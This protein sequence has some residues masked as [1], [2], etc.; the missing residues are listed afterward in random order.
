MDYYWLECEICNLQ[1]EKERGRKRGR[2]RERVGKRVGWRESLNYQY[3]W[4][5]Q[6][7]IRSNLKMLSRLCNHT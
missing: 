6:V 5:H 2:E 1:R 3:Q 4:L 7:G